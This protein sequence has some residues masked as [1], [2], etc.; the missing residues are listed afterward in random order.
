MYCGGNLITELPAK[1]DDTAC[2]LPMNMMMVIVMRVQIEPIKHN[3]QL[4]NEKRCHLEGKTK[5]RLAGK[6]VNCDQDINHPRDVEKFVINS[7][8]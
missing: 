5:M 3:P 7:V 2:N 4:L 1:K 6:L 8:L